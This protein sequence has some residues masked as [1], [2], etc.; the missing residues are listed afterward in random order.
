[1]DNL[2]QVV[3]VLTGKESGQFIR[4]LSESRSGRKDMELFNL[5]RRRNTIGEEEDVLDVLYSDG[6]RNAYHSL[7][8]RLLNQLTEFLVMQD[9]AETDK[10]S[11]SAISAFRTA[12]CLLN[13]NLPGVSAYYLQKAEKYARSQN[14]PEVL[15]LIYNFTITYSE[16]LSADLNEVVEKWRQNTVQLQKQQ[17]LNIAY[18]VIRKELAAARLSGT[19]LDPESIIESV[20]HDFEITTDLANNAAFMF[21]VVSMARS[22][23]VSTKDYYRLEP[24]LLRIY[25]GL[26]RVKA[27][28][29][30]DA[31]EELGFIYMIVHVLY[32]NRKFDE[33]VLWLHK[34]ESLLPLREFKKSAYYTKYIALSAAREGFTGNNA[35][36]IALLKSAMQDKH[37]R[38]A[39]AERLNFELNLSVYYFQSGEFRKSLKVLRDMGHSD[40]WL[41][42]KMGKEWRFKRS[43]IQVIVHCE[44][45]NDDLALS[46]IKAIEKYYSRF[47]SHPIYTR[48]KIFIGFIKKIILD[49]GI[50]RTSRFADDLAEARLGWPAEREDIQAITFFCWLK[51]K[52]INKKYYD[53]L[54]EAMNEKN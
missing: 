51:S 38:M 45:G 6:N 41:E 21:R 36:A 13:K 31:E 44:L 23:I 25:S 37:L 53:V 4:Y 52:M 22:A 12:R 26:K 32:R 15:D 9:V 28:E 34:M 24:Y 49:P 35:A 14:Q 16:E 29:K 50:A 20:F 3:S 18:A 10:E 30:R 43:L 7:R 5:I 33:M 27:F 42:L 54:V 47:L 39:A 19:T 1:M 8:K 17:K 48:A 40:R 11:S 46:Q 2:E